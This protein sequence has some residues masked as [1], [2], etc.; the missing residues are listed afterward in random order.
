M[1]KNKTR[2]KPSIHPV[3]SARVSAGTKKTLPVIIY[4]HRTILDIKDHLLE[5]Y[6][7]IKY[8]LPFMNAVAVEIHSEHIEK[9]AS[10]KMIKFIDDDAK[11]FKTMD[12]ASQCISTADI[13][14]L[15]AT[16]KSVGIAVVD[17]GVAPH[18]DLMK[19]TN[20]IIAFKDFVNNNTA[21]YDDDG[22]G[23]HVAGIIAGN[24]F[25]I[26]EYRGIASEA[27]IIAVKVLDGNGSGSTS[28][29]LAGIQWVI[30]HKDKYN[31][32][33]INLSLGTPADTIYKDD[34]LAKGASAAVEK[35]LTVV[36]AAGNSGPKRGTI[37]SP[38]ISPYVITVGAVD[39]N[40]TPSRND[41][42]VAD[43]SSRGPTASGLAKPDVVAPGVDIMS[44]SYTNLKGYVSQSGTSMATPMVSGAAALL[45]DKNPDLT[46][47]Q[48][49]RM[50]SYSCVTIRG[51]SRYSQGAGIINLKNMMNVQE[52]ENRRSR[53]PR[54]RRPSRTEESKPNINVPDLP[55]PS[56]EMNLLFLIYLLL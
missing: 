42:F 25:S 45:Y 32:K 31:I 1:S 20:R 33:I 23:T 46:P 24:G 35:G 34:P 28:D 53:N 49:K 19:P 7:K 10:H 11:V 17:T 16:G 2:A 9:I 5:Y 52:N 14:K 36:A 48:I 43:F 18:H 55:F 13:L 6:G 27:N 39:D 22:H 21:P 4:S 29:I 38:G 50:I 15:G 56:D 3:V 8:E 40:R 54:Y 37:N 41:S 26:P 30:D 12:I 51:V 44:L 47:A